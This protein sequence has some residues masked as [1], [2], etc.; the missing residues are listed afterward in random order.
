MNQEEEYLEV[1]DIGKDFDHEFSLH[2]RD[3]YFVESEEDSESEERKDELE[4][5]ESEEESER[6]KSEEESE[7]ET[8]YSLCRFHDRQHF[9]V[10]LLK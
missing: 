7:H 5:E 8:E 9:I 2:I 4:H 10:M 1:E 6:E 3:E